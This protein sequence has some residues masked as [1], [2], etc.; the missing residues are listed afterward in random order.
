MIIHN[1]D[2]WYRGMDKGEC[3]K[4]DYLEKLEMVLEVLPDRQNLHKCFYGDEFALYFLYDN[5]KGKNYILY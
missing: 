1:L 5:P 4:E 2:E 3:S